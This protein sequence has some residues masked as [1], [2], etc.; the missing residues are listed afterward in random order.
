MYTQGGII[1]I[2]KQ[3]T[4]FS[5]ACVSTALP[6]DEHEAWD[7]SKNKHNETNTRQRSYQHDVIH[8]HSST[9]GSVEFLK[10]QLLA[11]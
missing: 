11:V 4:L 5:L 1:F 9:S 10:R 2:R 6:P 7:V 3:L 8:A